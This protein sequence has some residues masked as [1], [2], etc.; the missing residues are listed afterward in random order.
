MDKDKDLKG[1]KK[2][3]NKLECWDPTGLILLISLIMS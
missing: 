2:P 3:L 1:K